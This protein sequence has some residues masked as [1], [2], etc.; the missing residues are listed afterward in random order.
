MEVSMKLK[1]MAAALGLLVSLSGAA[2]AKVES[3]EGMNMGEHW[4]GPKLS[5]SDL[6]G[7]VVMVEMWGFN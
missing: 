5:E 2:F 4:A 3:L 6:K 1:H 7:R